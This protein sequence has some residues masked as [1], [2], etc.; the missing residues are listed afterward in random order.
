MSHAAKRF[1]WPRMN[2]EIQ[3][4]RYEWIPCKKTDKNIRPQ[5]TMTEVKFLP[6]TENPNQE[7]QLDFFGPISFKHRRF[8]ILV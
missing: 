6:L 5:L 4:K 3:Q 7:I 2:K 1:W 8:F